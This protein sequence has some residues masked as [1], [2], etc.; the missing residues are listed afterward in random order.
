VGEA[1][2]IVGRLAF[3]DLQQVFFGLG[4]AFEPRGRARN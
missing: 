4:D 3:T 2:P 1:E